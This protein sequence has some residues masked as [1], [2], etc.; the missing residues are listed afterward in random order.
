MKQESARWLD[1]WKD[2][3]VYVTGPL[4]LS[5]VALGCQAF[6]TGQT[7]TVPAPT[8]PAMQATVTVILPTPPPA[9]TLTAMVEAYRK[10]ARHTPR[11]PNDQPNPDAGTGS[12]RYH[13]ANARQ[14]SI[15]QPGTGGE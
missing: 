3:I 14:Q 5:L 7:P 11:P 6:R 10:H 4:F 12:R 1:G 13:P 2:R 15:H 8:R 9:A